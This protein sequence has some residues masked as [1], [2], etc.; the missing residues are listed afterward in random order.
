M[1]SDPNV[2]LKRYIQRNKF[3]KT[4][5]FKELTIRKYTLLLTRKV[6]EQT[7]LFCIVLSFFHNQRSKMFDSNKLNSKKKKRHE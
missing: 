7:L 5:T 1:N 6:K 4:K 2:S 3:N